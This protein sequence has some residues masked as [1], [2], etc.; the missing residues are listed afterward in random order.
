MYRNMNEKQ[1]LKIASRVVLGMTR[2][3]AHD[4]NDAVR[5]MDLTLKVFASELTDT[6][7]SGINGT[8]RESIDLEKSLVYL[9]D[10]VLR[11][12]VERF[13]G[14]LAKILN[15][16]ESEYRRNQDDMVRHRQKCYD[17]KRD[18]INLKKNILKWGRRA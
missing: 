1:I 15:R 2:S 14:E 5:S 13:Q 16:A 9:D 8:A 4:W 3:E 6:D 7:L 11:R 18:V 12:E 10:L 17:I